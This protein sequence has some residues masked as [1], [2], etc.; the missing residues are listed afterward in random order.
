MLLIPFSRMCRRLLYQQRPLFL[1]MTFNRLARHEHTLV[2]TNK[3]SMCHE[4]AKPTSANTPMKTVR[5][6]TETG[7][8]CQTNDKA[9]YEIC[10]HGVRA[11]KLI[12]LVDTRSRGRALHS[13]PMLGG[14][15]SRRGHG[16][17]QSRANHSTGESQSRGTTSPFRVAPD[18]VTLP[19]RDI[20]RTRTTIGE[21]NGQHKQ[22]TDS[23]CPTATRSTFRDIE[24]S[25]SSEETGKESENRG[26][27]LNWNTPEPRAFAENA[28]EQ[29]GHLIR[30]GQP[31]PEQQLHKHDNSVPPGPGSRYINYLIHRGEPTCH[32]LRPACHSHRRSAHEIWRTFPNEKHVILGKVDKSGKKS[33]D[34]SI[35][36]LLNKVNAVDDF[37]TLSSCSGRAY[38][39]TTTELSESNPKTTASL[40]D[41]GPPSK[42]YVS[43]HDDWRFHVCHTPEEWNPK[44]A[45]QDRIQRTCR[46]EGSAALCST[47]TLIA[48]TRCSVRRE[49][50]TQRTTEKNKDG[51]FLVAVRRRAAEKQDLPVLRE[52]AKEEAEDERE[53]PMCFG[54]EN[55]GCD[56]GSGATRGPVLPTAQCNVAQSLVHPS[57]EPAVYWVRFEPFI[58]HVACRSLDAAFSFIEASRA[59][60]PATSLLAFGKRYV[61]QVPGEDYLETP[62]CLMPQSLL[63]PVSGA[64]FFAQASA[65][66]ESEAEHGED[67]YSS[68]LA[69]VVRAKFERNA[70][71]VRQ[72]EH[73]LEKILGPAPT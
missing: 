51:D 38:L 18:T 8:S 40:K 15:D 63:W 52:V 41:V 32:D 33:W 47:S 66:A 59:A 13:R 28:A 43:H 27:M 46:P 65:A 16:P 31:E 69:R 22:A 60:F 73:D 58:L 56:R 34:A 48:E 39:W 14:L 1:S 53:T 35:V 11:A 24:I 70:K 36:P 7:T 26:P 62:Y 23:M 19:A 72:L 21:D 17:D 71:R 37:C 9:K 20:N 54:G 67:L 45:L 25:A 3:S 42:K 29:G 4:S 12:S 50:V 68:Y 6:E 64:P 30:R 61:V 49:Q 2:T 5:A 55:A 57:H 44:G 10:M